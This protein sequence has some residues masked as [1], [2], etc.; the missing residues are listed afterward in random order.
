MAAGQ[1]TLVR[2]GEIT[3]S[4]STGT[5]EGVNIPRSVKTTLS[6]LN[7]SITSVNS[8]GYLLQVGDE[9]PQYTNNN[10]DGAIIEGNRLTWN[11]T[12]ASSITH[13]LFTGYNINYSIK[14]NYLDKAPYGLIFKSGNDAGVNMSY[15]NG[16]GAAYNI[17]KNARLSVRMK[18]MNGVQIYNNT[19]YTNQRSGSVI[20]IDANHDRT[21]PASSTGAK[22]K[23]NIFYT[24]Y[25]IPNI[26][27]EAGCLQNFESDYNVF[28]CESGEP[29][30]SVDGVLKSFSQWQSMG[31]DRHSVVVNPNFL[32]TTEFVPRSRLNYGVNLG[33]TW[34]KGLSTTARWVAGSSPETTVQNGT[35]QAGAII[36]P[37]VVVPV[38][39]TPVYI[40]SVI[41]NAT[42]S[43]LEMTYN[44]QLAS[45]VPAISAFR[46]TVNSVTRTINSVAIT[47]SK[48][49]LT[50]SSPVVYGDIITISYTKPTANMLQTSSGGQ[51]ASISAKP[52]TNKVAYVPPPPPP[53]PP[54]TTT[55]PPIVTNSPPVI[56]I[57]SPTSISSGFVGEIDA[58]TS[59][60][61]NHDNLS[62]SWVVP[63]NIPVSSTSAS[64]IKFLGPVLDDTRTFDFKLNISDGKTVR[65]Q[66]VSVD[67]VPY[68]PELE[69]ADIVKIEASE[70]QPPHSPYNIIDGNIGTM[71]SADGDNQWL[72]LDLKE[73]FTIQ[74]LKLSFLPG[75][76]WASYFDIYGS[77]DDQA[78]EPILVKATSCDFS[79]DLQ[80]FDFPPSKAAKEFN[81][82]KF[83]GHTNS[84]NNWNYIS[85]IK[86]FGYN[87]HNPTSF[88]L[89]PVKLFPN[90]ANYF[91]NIRIDDLS[92]RP[93]FIKIMN[94]SG[95]IVF[96]NKMDPDVLDFQF[97]LNLERGIYVIQIGA[98]D[99]TLYTQK[100]IIIS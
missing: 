50:L 74:H 84:A 12:D 31:Y 79:G 34:Q 32:N 21:Q 24:I 88:E 61:P 20:M 1:V 18:G 33:S 14:Y 54:P 98:G 43:L 95:K 15:S 25:R 94:L 3:N 99:L 42:P 9:V 36:Y 65:S 96:Q 29:V 86:I 17:I 72:I 68:K 5:W 19:F 40:V 81:F 62:Y 23:N 35:W 93:D 85:E 49:L 77:E 90:P 76:E 47:G 80:V 51:A 78:W 26:S 58:S 45:I 67:V 4:T 60:D 2:E 53:P 73:P 22:I 55:N 57:N 97:P 89:Q 46:V 87:H 82:I 38:P 71:W 7:N 41:E 69:V 75:Q 8:S 64:K 92:M 28:Y 13:G 27:V 48:V 39:A 100:L 44:L 66:T 11:G 16:Y 30:F 56:V 83:V 10:L 37:E 52:V 91:V 70:F 6:Y 59:Y 63:S